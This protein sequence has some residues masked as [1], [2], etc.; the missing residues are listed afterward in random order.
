[1]KTPDTNYFMLRLALPMAPFCGCRRSQR[2]L[3]VLVPLSGRKF[4]SR[5]DADV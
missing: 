2:R 1:M 5:K 3:R 4:T